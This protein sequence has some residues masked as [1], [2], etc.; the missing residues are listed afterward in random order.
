MIDRKRFFAEMERRG[1]K[2]GP[3]GWT[4]PQRE[5]PYNRQMKRAQNQ[6]G[7]AV[8]E[9]ELMPKDCER[10]WRK[11]FDAQGRRKTVA[12]HEDYAKP[13]EVVWL[14]R[15]CHMKRH[16]EMERERVTLL[17][18]NVSSMNVSRVHTQ[19]SNRITVE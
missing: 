8:R 15:R 9:G 17:S 1:C 5:R 18:K 11:R 3:D 16:K 10:C 4:I 6:L 7:F 14:C 19:S 13:L 12:H 2:L